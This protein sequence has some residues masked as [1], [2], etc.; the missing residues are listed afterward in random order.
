MSAPDLRARVESVLKART[1]GPVSVAAVTPLTG[2]ACQ[3][4]FRVEVEL[5]GEPTVFAL[6][7]D[8]RTALP[9]SIRRAAEHA[10]IEAAVSVGVPTPRARWL[11]ADLVRPGAHAYFLDWLDGEAIGA[12]V[13]CHPRVAEARA[14]L[15]EQLGAALAAVHRVT[16]G[17]HPALPVDREPF[18]TDADPARAALR[19]ARGMLDRLPRPRPA[20]ELALRWLDAHRP[21]RGPTTLVHADFRTGN[22]MVTSQGLAGVL[23]WEFAHWGDPMEDIGWLCVR[24]WRF[25]C[26]D[27]PAGGLCDRRT[28]AR[29]YEAAGGAAVDPDRV[30]WWEVCGN[31]RWGAAAAFQGLRFAEGEDDFELLAIPRRAAEMEY[32]ALRLIE[33]GPPSRRGQG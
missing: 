1:D 14:A 16:P 4:N 6:R 8:A 9:G 22:F 31:L 15:P 33:L 23:D 28:F 18:H 17:T 13:T 21:K 32:E 30:H 24:D 10:V 7:S 25:G 26:V 11:T 12:R 2:G 19:F 27:R 3:E 20:C 29:A 5:A